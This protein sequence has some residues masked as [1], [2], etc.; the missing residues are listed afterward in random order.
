MSQ[1]LKL[2]LLVVGECKS[3]K[4]SFIKKYMDSE[5]EVNDSVSTTYASEAY[6]KQIDFSEGLK[7]FLDIWDSYSGDK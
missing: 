4:T 5:F 3:G 7:L 6:Q 2:R 1:L